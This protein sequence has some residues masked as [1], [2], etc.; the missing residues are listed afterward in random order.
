MTEAPLYYIN[1]RRVF[2]RSVE[3]KHPDGSSSRTMGF[4][5]CVIEE[6]VEGGAEFVCAALNA[7]DDDG[8]E[9]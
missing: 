9:Q 4:V 3:T 1:G 2:K 6:F 8:Q 7:Y 5:V